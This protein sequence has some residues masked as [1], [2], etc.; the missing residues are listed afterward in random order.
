MNAEGKRQSEKEEEKAEEEKKK[1]RNEME[2][3]NIKL[4]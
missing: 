1:A 4:H 2:A 3:Q